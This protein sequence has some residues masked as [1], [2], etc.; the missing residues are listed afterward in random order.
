MFAEVLFGL[1]GAKFY[2]C[3]YEYNWYEERRYAENSKQEI[4]QCQPALCALDKH[5]ESGEDTQCEKEYRPQLIAFI[6][7]SRRLCICLD[8]LSFGSF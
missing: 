1:L 3:V 7:R 8:R 5:H 4:M 6:L 2:R